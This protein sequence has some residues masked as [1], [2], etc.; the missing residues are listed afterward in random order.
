MVEAGDGALIGFGGFA[1]ELMIDLV[2][3]CLDGDL[4]KAKEAQQT[5]APLARSM[6]QRQMSAN[7]PSAGISVNVSF[8]LALCLQ[9]RT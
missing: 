6:L 8:M 5:V 4:A 9:C 1:P 2:H 3:G 7:S